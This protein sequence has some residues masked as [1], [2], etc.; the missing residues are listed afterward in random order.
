M[1][2]EPACHTPDGAERLVRRHWGRGL[3]AVLT[4]EK[5]SEA[6]CSRTENT[7]LETVENQEPQEPESDLGDQRRELAF[8]QVNEVTWKLTDGRG[9]IAWS[10]DRSGGY[11]TTRA[12][13]WLMG[14]GGGRWIVRYRNKASKP[15]RLPKARD[16]ALEMVKGVWAGQTLI[17]PIHHPHQACLKMMEEVPRRASWLPKRPVCSRVTVTGLSA[18]TCNLSRDP[19]FGLGSMVTRKSGASASSEVRW[20]TAGDPYPRH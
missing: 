17:D 3:G 6:E 7:A 8:E 20:Q 12:I 9:S 14:V 4:P 1:T 19:F 11:R 5:L 16:Y 2:E 13:A 15:M 18:I 10:G